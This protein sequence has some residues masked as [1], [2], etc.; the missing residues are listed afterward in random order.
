MYKQAGN[1]IVVDVLENLIKCLF[2][3]IYKQNELLDNIIKVLSTVGVEKIDKIEDK[4]KV[5][6]NTIGSSSMFFKENGTYFILKID[7]LVGLSEAINTSGKDYLNVGKKMNYDCIKLL[8]AIN[9]EYSAKCYTTSTVELSIDKLFKL[10]EREN[11]CDL[12]KELKKYLQILKNMSI[13][14]YEIPDGQTLG[15]YREVRLCDEA[16][17]LRDKIRFT[18]SNEMYDFLKN[19]G[20]YTYMSTDVINSLNAN[21]AYKTIL[22]HK[23]ANARID[24]ENVISVKELY[25]VLDLPRYK[26][27]DKHF[28]RILAEFES[29]LNTINSMEWQYDIETNGRY[30]KWV[31]SSIIIK[32]KTSPFIENVDDKDSLSE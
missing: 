1:S 21:L 16:R 18:F 24:Q 26:K 20:T 17:L 6:V 29:A 8:E 31:N 14:F 9:I 5:V 13:A 15:N 3:R 12:K 7:N 11:K 28:G 27:G 30:K 4:N 2:N 19:N 32:W 23:K 22:A 25:D 10:Y